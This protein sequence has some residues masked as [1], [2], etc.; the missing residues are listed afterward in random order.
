[1]GCYTMIFRFNFKKFLISV[2]IPLAVGGMSALVT[3]DNMQLYSNIKVPPLSPPSW[4]FPVVWSILYTLMGIS[5]YLVINSKGIEFNKQRAFLFYFLQLFLN[6]I[7]SPI[8]FNNKKYCV[9]L[10]ILILLWVAAVGMIINFYK[11][12]KPAGVLQIPYII[13]LIFAVYL[14]F[15]IC[16]LN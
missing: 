9:A 15:T 10:I 16:L 14:N 6:F 1:M 3:K 4:L 11:I 2:L 7:W 8:F 5:F 12:S 13:W